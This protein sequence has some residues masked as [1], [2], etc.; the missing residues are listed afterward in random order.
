MNLPYSKSGLFI[1]TTKTEQGSQRHQWDE[2]AFGLRVVG[3]FFQLEAR[4]NANDDS[5]I[6][7]LCCNCKLYIFVLMN[8]L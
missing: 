8:L 7:L 1:Q 4:P 2:Y 5:K 3:T 6:F